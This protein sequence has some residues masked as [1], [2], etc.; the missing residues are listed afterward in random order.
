SY[1]LS[2]LGKLWIAGA[3]VD[4]AGFNA[5]HRRHRVRLPPYPFERQRYWIEPRRKA[6]AGRQNLISLEKEA[7]IADW[8]YIP[9]W[10]QSVPLASMADFDGENQ[11]WLIFVDECEVSSG[12][13]E[14]LRALNQNVLAVQA[15]EKFYKVNDGVFTINPRAAD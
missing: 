11:C 6:K 10:K 7:D 8:F 1:L 14:R 15:G 5:H 13:V 2:T 9:I 4:W 3:Q 12:I